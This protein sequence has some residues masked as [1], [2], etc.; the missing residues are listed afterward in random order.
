MAKDGLFLGGIDMNKKFLLAWYH[1]FLWI[2]HNMLGHPIAGFFWMLGF[3]KVGDWIHDSTLPPT[4]KDE[5]VYWI[6]YSRSGKPLS[7][8]WLRKELY[9]QY[10]D[11]GGMLMFVPYNEYNSADQKFIDSVF[12]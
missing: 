8:H 12:S 3:D 9:G 10:L 11:D 1:E 5:Y 7:A 2:I 4:D 6:D